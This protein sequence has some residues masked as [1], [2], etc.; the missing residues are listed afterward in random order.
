MVALPPKAL[1]VLWQLARQAGQVV[2]KATLLDTVWAETAVSEGTLTNCLSLLRQALGEDARQPRYIATVHRVGYR[3]VA[4]VTSGK[5]PLSSGTPLAP[6]AASSPLTLSPPPLVVGRQAELAQLHAGWRQTLH[7]ARQ[8][9]FIT[10]EAGI[11]KTTLVEAFLAQLEPTMPCWIGHGQCIE[12]YGAGEAYLPLLEALGQ[13]GR[14]PAGARLVATLRQVAP[15]WLAQLPALWGAE[16]RAGLPHTLQ[17]T[18]RTRMLRELV[19]ALELLSTVQPLGLVLEDLHWSDASTVEALALLA[20]RREAA[21]LLVLGTYRPVELILHEH[22]LK[23]LKQELVAHG[24][25]RELPLGGLGLEAVET[26]LAQRADVAGAA[27]ADLAAVVYRRTEGHPLFMVQVVDALAQPGDLHVPD[28]A[29]VGPG[30]EGHARMVPL[31]LRELLEAQLGRLGT[32]EQQVLEVGSVAGAE[33]VVASVAAGL[34]MAPAA[35]EA[36][37]EGL[38]RQGRFL[39]DRG[40]AEWPDGTV[41]G[42]YGWRHALYQEVVYQQMG[43]GHRARLHRRI[44]A[45]LEA[46]YQ[47]QAST[48]ATAL[49]LHFERGH[50]QARAVHYL[51]QAGENATRRSAHREAIALLTQGLALLAQLP[52]TPARAQQELDLQLALGPALMATKGQSAPEVEQTYA[53]ARQLCAQV[54]ETPQLFPT[55]WGLQRFYG[56]RGALPTAQE[57]GEQLL[58]LAQRTADP[59]HRLEAH[60]ALGITLYYLGDYAAAWWHLAQGIALTDPAVQRA[61]ALRH[62]VAPGV[63]G[64]ATA[65]NTLWCLG[66]PAQAVRRSQEALVL[67]QEL[68]H[69]YSLAYAQNWAAVLHHRRRDVPAVQ[70]QA[71]ALLALAT[72]QGFSVYAGWGIYW[73]G[74]ALAMQGQGTA[75]LTQMQQGLEAIFATQTLIQPLC[76]LLLAEATGHV[77]QV[78]EGLRLLAEALGVFEA[79]GRGDLLAEAYRLQGE[80]LL[81]QAVPEVA[82]A[83]AC[84]QQALAIAR[85]QEAKAWELRVATSLAQLWQRQGKRAEAYHLLD[86]VY[87]WFTEGCDTAELQ[88]AR[89]LLDALKIGDVL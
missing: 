10:G 19:N 36:V 50:E 7:G 1:A 59:T 3:F 60:E 72:A 31:G 4:P 33:F 5:V 27:R 22:P 74:W 32:T 68:D 15:T 66:Y 44:G 55:L 81:R 12:H 29:A 73:R 53:R 62:G 16:D 37:C 2:S 23:T 42:R 21:R 48:H 86:V 78:V 77:G 38:A 46:G 26:Y 64:L 11:G 84:L 34:E 30:E 41:S 58:R 28:L 17:S 47:E 82:K 6:V 8:T 61:L 49:A 87:G 75:G 39:E 76:L 35:V 79:S 65:A 14:G 80:F 57:L 40:L 25:A 83:E 13:L 67:A 70:A 52:E 20:R 88:E 43:A 89:A 71:E 56:N 69:P 18:T 24:Q 9:V 63:G 54:G 85:R 51:R 45:R